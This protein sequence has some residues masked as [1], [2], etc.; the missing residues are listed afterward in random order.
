VKHIYRNTSTSIIP[1]PSH[2]GQLFPAADVPELLHDLQAWVSST[3]T[4]FTM[5]STIDFT[6]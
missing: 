6:I 4:S 3:V 1:V 5:M 2:A